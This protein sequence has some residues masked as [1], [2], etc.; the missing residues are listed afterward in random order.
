MD[1]DKKTIAVDFDGVINPYTKGWQGP[2]VFEK[3]SDRCAVAMKRL[4]AKYVVIIHTARERSEFGAI[5]KY[6]KLNDIKHDGIFT[7]LGKRAKPPAVAYLD[8]KAVLFSGD[9]DC[10]PADIDKSSSG[11][12]EVFEFTAKEQQHN[13][14]FKM[15][16]GKMLSIKT[17]ATARY[18][19]ESWNSLGPKGIFVDINRKFARVKHFVWEGNDQATSE[20]IEDTLFDMAVYSLLMVMSLRG[21]E[22]CSKDLSTTP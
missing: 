18:G 11:G 16:V 8:D 1:K 19:V 9:W 7:A 13:N 21:R 20:N 3:P 5:K 6:L 2:G 4:R 17:D 15:L 14:M 12:T 22:K 10:V